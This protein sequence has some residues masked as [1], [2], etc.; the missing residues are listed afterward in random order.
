MTSL[1]CGIDIGGTFTDCAVLRE[2]GE[3]LVGKAFTTYDDFSRGFFEAL[4]TVARQA[5]EP[6]EELI[7]SI[8]R[9]GH[10][11]TI[12]TNAVVQRRGAS[13][14]LITTR[15]HADVLRMMKGAGRVIGL[16]PEELSHVQVQEKPPTIV[17]RGLVEEVSERID[18]DGDVVVEL[19]EDEVRA[20]AERLAEAGV[21]AI[22][23]AF[24]W[25]IKNRDHEHRA[26]DIVA[27]VAPD[28]FVTCASDL[29]PKLGEYGRFSAAVINGYIGPATEGYLGR[30]TVRAEERGY[31]QP[32][33]VMQAGGGMLDLPSARRFPLLTL[34]SGPVAGVTA[35]TYL[36]KQLG[37]PN[38]ICTDMGGTSFDV[39]LIVDGKPLVT[40]QSAIGQYEYFV[41]AVD[42][43]SIGAGGGSIATLDDHG[44]LKVGPR[45]AGSTP[46]PACYGRGG[47]E[48]TVTDANVV[49][50]RIDPSYFLG[51]EIALDRAAAERAIQPIAEGLGITTIEAAA[52]ITKIVEFRMADLIRNLTVGMGYDPRDFVV[53]AYGGAGPVH[54]AAFSRELGVQ[55]LIIPMGKVSS[56]WSAMGAATADLVRMFER[57]EVMS[58]PLDHERLQAG[59][60]ALEREA[61]EWL[62]ELSAGVSSTTFERSV[63]MRYQA[64]VHEVTIPVADGAVDAA[65]A[66][67]IVADFQRKYD[68]LYGEGAGF[69]G[70]QMEIESMRVTAV[71]AM[72]KPRVAGEPGE[73]RTPEPDLHRDVYWSDTKSTV[74]TP[75]YRGDGLTAGHSVAGPAIVELPMTSVVLGS[76]QSA[77]IDE[78]GNVVVAL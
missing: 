9:L 71:G 67:Q 48:A 75:I 30:L 27:E 65:V 32:L 66:Q 34:Q 44:S 59:F 7:G 26:R 69:P 72:Q 42:I 43:Q 36:G 73:A 62:S 8:E 41:S 39:G 53:Y 52:G 70:A 58:A 37:M 15:G 4:E 50:G 56:G 61:Q 76:G 54:A 5:G 74:S 24:L 33:L 21:E 12:G 20:A 3:V 63:E 35:A 13:V 10:G 51:G 2:D 23:I 31:R 55:S 57:V 47:T 11:T 14:G 68:E 19:N 45:S 29:V 1:L 22:V 40:S 64:Q 38:I 17:P 49:L 16:S 77:S 25:A 6:V 28:V 18:A 46:G 60:D 78:Y